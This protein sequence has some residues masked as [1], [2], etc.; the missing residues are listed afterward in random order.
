MKGD[1][2]NRAGMRGQLTATVGKHMRNALNHADPGRAYGQST[3]VNEV[4]SSGIN[5]YRWHR[6]SS[7][8][9]AP[10]E[11]VPVKAHGGIENRR[12]ESIAQG[13]PRESAPV[14]DCLPWRVCHAGLRSDGRHLWLSGILLA[15]S[16]AA[17]ASGCGQR[18]TETRHDAQGNP[19]S[20]EATATNSA[21]ER[22]RTPSAASPDGGRDNSTS[23]DQSWKQT[24]IYAFL[25]QP[26]E[27][28]IQSSPPVGA[29]R[30]PD[31]TV[32]EKSVGK[33]F[34]T[35]RQRWPEI[36]FV[37]ATGQLKRP[38]AEL[39]TELGVIEIE[40]WPEVA[41]NHVR[42]FV[43]LAECGYYDGLFFELRVGNR[44]A[45]DV[46]RAIG[47]G[48][49]EA[50]A[51]ETASIGFWL[52]PEILLPEKAAA[53]GIRHRPG[54]VFCHWLGCFFYIG[55]TEAPMWD[56]E[57]VIFGQVRQGLETAERIFDALGEDAHPP[58]I[59]RVRIRWQETGKS[60]KQLP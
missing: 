13:D 48:S 42:A 59:R 51:L 41:P 55:L 5:P 37:T 2:L 18:G 33:L 57:Y 60:L 44:G 24:P 45:A 35:V 50:N 54:S 34:E 7:A 12:R 58:Q 29:R 14:P 31:V 30:P 40:L 8:H 46:P 23:D 32:T 20:P 21:S 56:G 17:I 22:W 53:R 9:A 27:E 10:Q 52:K 1:A 6:E 28:A 3:P 16:L 25:H 26:F 43:A 38:L 4:T 19:N 36:V 47:G 15:L 39:D 11:S 49:P